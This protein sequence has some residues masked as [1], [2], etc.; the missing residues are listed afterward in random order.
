[1]K[2]LLDTA[3][4]N[5]SRIVI[6]IMLALVLMVAVVTTSLIT[7]STG[8]PADPIGGGNGGSPNSQPTPTPPGG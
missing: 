8:I 5:A 6:V 1:M 4:K 7:P 3:L 2:Q